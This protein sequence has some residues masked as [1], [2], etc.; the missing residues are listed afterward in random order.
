M[1]YGTISTD[2]TPGTPEMENFRGFPFSPKDV[3]APARAL[4]PLAAD[5][6]HSH[7]FLNESG[8]E[9]DAEGRVMRLAMKEG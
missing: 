3:S 4:A 1:Y 9:T 5:V 8:G 2:S 6:L 7:K